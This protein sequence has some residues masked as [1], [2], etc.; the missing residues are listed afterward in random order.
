MGEFLWAVLNGCVTA[1]APQIGAL[2]GYLILKYIFR[3]KETT[4]NET[5]TWVVGLAFW[6]ILFVG[7]YIIYHYR[8][9]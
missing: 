8:Q 1:F 7:I 6:I 4:F 3:R 2:P 9:D 5:I